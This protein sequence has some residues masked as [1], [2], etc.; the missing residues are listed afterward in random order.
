MDT[1]HWKDVSAWGLVPVILPPKGGGKP[2]QKMSFVSWK[3]VQNVI[4]HCICDIFHMEDLWAKLCYGLH[5]AKKT[6][7]YDSLSWSNFQDG[8]K[9]SL[10]FT[11][12][13]Q[14][15]ADFCSTALTPVEDT[16][17]TT[18]FSTINSF[19]HLLLET[20]NTAVHGPCN[21]L[22]PKQW[23]Y[24]I[25]ILNVLQIQWLLHCKPRGTLD[26]SAIENT[27]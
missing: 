2:F 21:G 18:L 15:V 27:L 8:Y 5:K 24:L 13:Q 26:A 3:Q 12:L 23:T 9:R 20:C 11:T 6:H 10:L 7:A 14:Q 22:I 1:E 25:S 19:P 17:F 16:A 4:L